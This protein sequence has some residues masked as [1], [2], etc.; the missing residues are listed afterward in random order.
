MITIPGPVSAAPP[1]RRSVR[2]RR[3]A[4]LLAVCSSLFVVAVP[5]TAEA[6]ATKTAPHC[7]QSA[8]KVVC[9]DQDHQTLW[10]QQG[11]KIIFSPVRIRTGMPGRRTPDGL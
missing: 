10:V 11:K 4:A 8:R 3:V 6:A 1:R 2:G 7:P 5:A 9:V